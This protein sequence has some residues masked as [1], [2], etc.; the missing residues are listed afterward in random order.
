MNSVLFHPTQPLIATSGIERFVRLF[1]HFPTQPGQEAIKQS[2]TRELPERPDPSIVTRALTG[3]FTTQ[4]DFNDEESAEAEDL[5]DTQTGAKRELATDGTFIFIGFEPNN[6]LV[7]A[8]V[9]M[10]AD[11]Y[12]I[13][14]DKCETKIPGLYVVGDLRAKYARQIVVAAADGCTAALAAAH[15]VESKKASEA[16][17]LPADLAD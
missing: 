12:V 16:C 9:N 11:G 3:D 17:E 4:T 13:T 15:Y 5:E 6:Q 8:G 1:T 14:D 2:E 10:D 7:P